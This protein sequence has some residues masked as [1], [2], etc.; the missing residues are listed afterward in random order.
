MW[1][2][3]VRERWVEAGVEVEVE[4]G[5]G[6]EVEV[7]VEVEIEV[8]VEVEV[9]GPGSCVDVGVEDS[10]EGGGIGAV[11]EDNGGG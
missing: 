5:V 4:I 3:R 1:W 2:P 7:E 11:L 8:E 10:W 6:V 9:V